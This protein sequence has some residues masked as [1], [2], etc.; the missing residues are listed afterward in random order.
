MKMQYNNPM[1]KILFKKNV[2]PQSNWA[3]GEDTLATATTYLEDFVL[4]QTD[5][6]EGDKVS[7]VSPRNNRYNFVVAKKCMLTVI[8]GPNV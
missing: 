7:I 2:I 8:P 3:N 1:W 6:S 5:I 4:T